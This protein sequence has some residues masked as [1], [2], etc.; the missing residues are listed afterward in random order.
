MSRKERALTGKSDLKESFYIY[1]IEGIL[2]FH[3]A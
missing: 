3:F 1:S 2:L